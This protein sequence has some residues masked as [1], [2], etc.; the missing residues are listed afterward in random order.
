MQKDRKRSQ[1]FATSRKKSQK[2]KNAK[3]RNKYADTRRHTQKYAKIAKRFAKRTRN[4]THKYAEQRGV[5]TNTYCRNTQKYTKIRKNTYRYIEIR[6]NTQE[7]A[8][9]RTN[10]QKYTKI[11]NKGLLRLF[12]MRQFILFVCAAIMIT[13]TTTTKRSKSF[14]HINVLF[15]PIKTGPSAAKTAQNA[16]FIFPAISEQR[17]MLAFQ[18]AGDP[19]ILSRNLYFGAKSVVSILPGILPDIHILKHDGSMGRFTLQ[20]RRK[21]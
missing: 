21:L 5:R 1:K 9:I 16:C 12:Y 13:T 18:V 17:L 3:I 20:T 19:S 7:Y 14:R 15:P 11:Y 2:R 4:N 8:K 6:R 10:A